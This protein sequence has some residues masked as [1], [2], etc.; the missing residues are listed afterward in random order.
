MYHIAH[1]KAHPQPALLNFSTG[2]TVEVTPALNI[3]SVRMLCATATSPDDKK[4]DGVA[5][6]ETRLAA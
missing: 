4:R 1:G 5:F 3:L 2:Q 6:N